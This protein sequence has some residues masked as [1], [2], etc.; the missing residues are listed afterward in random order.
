[1]RH[2]TPSHTERL[3]SFFNALDLLMM[4]LLVVVVFAALLGAQL[5]QRNYRIQPIYRSEPFHLR[6]NINQ[7]RQVIVILI[8]KIS[9]NNNCKLKLNLK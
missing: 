3:L 5:F 8:V 9:I 4:V 7:S 6:A 1:M 2:Y